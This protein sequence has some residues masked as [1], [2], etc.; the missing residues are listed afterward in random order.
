LEKK[1]IGGGQVLGQRARFGNRVDEARN[2]RKEGAARWLR[3]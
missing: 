1:K 2:I 3:Q